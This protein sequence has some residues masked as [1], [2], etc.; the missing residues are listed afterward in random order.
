[1]PLSVFVSFPTTTNTTITST[2]SEGQQKITTQ[3]NFLIG[4]DFAF[5]GQK[6]T[7][8]GGYSPTC[9]KLE[10]PLKTS[11]SLETIIVIIVIIEIGQHRDSCDIM[12]TTKMA[13]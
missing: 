10:E 1:M 13:E 12:F 4:Q 2:S 7:K 3:T 6:F 11:E 5:V 8:S 9:A